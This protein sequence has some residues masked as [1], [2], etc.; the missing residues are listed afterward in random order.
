MNKHLF[1]YLFCLGV[2]MGCWGKAQ[3]AKA[4]DPNP[5]RV[6][7]CRQTQHLVRLTPNPTFTGALA[8]ASECKE[9]LHFYVFDVEG[10]L[11]FHALLL[12]GNNRT[13]SE[14]KQGEY[15]YDVFRKDE[16]VEQGKITVRNTKKKQGS[17]AR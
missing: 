10:T 14:L 13:I 15:S 11:V 17:V 7:V 12:P 2:T 4:Y 5:I 1:L 16:S 9:S 6:K 3:G 8:V